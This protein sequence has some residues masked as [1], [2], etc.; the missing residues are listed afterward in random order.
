VDQGNAVAKTITGSPAPY[1]AVPWFWTDQF[2]IRMQMAGLAPTWDELVT[3]GDPASRRFSVFYFQGGAL[4]AVDSI[5]RPADHLAARRL[6]GMRS[7]ITPQQAADEAF[8][9]KSALP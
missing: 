9:L 8:D 2:D 4:K 6:I 1:A 7:P 5:N 3:R